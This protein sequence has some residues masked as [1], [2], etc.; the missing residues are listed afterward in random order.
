VST[1]RFLSALELSQL[2]ADQADYMPDTC[3]ILRGT[4]VANAIGE[5]GLAWGTVAASAA[6]RLRPTGLKSDVGDMSGQLQTYHSW[7]LYIA[8]AGT[9]LPGDRVVISGGTFEVVQ[10]W[11]EE[12]WPTAIKADVR[13]LEA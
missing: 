8:Q 3:D 5:A 7:N 11:E 1:H 2:R 6:C 13:R 9:L 4:A 10:S 12:S